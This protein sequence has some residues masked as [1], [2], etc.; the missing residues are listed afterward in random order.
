MTLCV[1]ASSPNTVLLMSPLMTDRNSFGARSHARENAILPARQE[2]R[3]AAKML[4]VGGVNSK[5]CRGNVRPMW[6]LFVEMPR[7][8][9]VD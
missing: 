4:G 8:K 5:K 3:A 1:T 7:W 9:A 2:P 6:D